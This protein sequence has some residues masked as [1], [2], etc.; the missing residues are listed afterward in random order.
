MRIAS[1]R[2]ILIVVGTL[3]ILGGSATPA[4]A[5][6]R[7]PFTISEPI[8]AQFVSVPGVVFDSDFVGVCDPQLQCYGVQLQITTPGANVTVGPG[9]VSL[10]GAVC[11]LNNVAPCAGT[12]VFFSDRR[13]EMSH[14]RS[15]TPPTGKVCVW[16]GSP[17]DVPSKCVPIPASIVDL[18]GSETVD[19]G[20]HIPQRIG[21]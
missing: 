5:I 2:R 20:Q 4:S 6:V 9:V 19:L 15:V 10:V 13:A 21:V 11:V 1:W 14:S 8:G 7:I 18:N 12:G 3:A 16:A 17:R